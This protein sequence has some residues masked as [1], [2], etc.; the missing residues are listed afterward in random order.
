VDGQQH[1]TGDAGGFGGGVFCVLE[2]VLVDCL[3]RIVEQNAVAAQNGLRCHLGD[4][5]AQAEAELLE[6]FVERQEGGGNGGTALGKG[7]NLAVGALIE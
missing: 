6:A 5:V 4:V 7:V 2:A 1:R 3:S